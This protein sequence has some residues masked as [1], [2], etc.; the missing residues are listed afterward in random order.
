MPYA[1]QVGLFYPMAIKED[2]NTLLPQ[3]IN[4]QTFDNLTEKDLGLTSLT[5]LSSCLTESNSNIFPSQIHYTNL[6]NNYLYL[7]IDDQQHLQTQKIASNYIRRLLYGK[8]KVMDNIVYDTTSGCSIMFWMQNDFTNKDIKEV[9]II[10]DYNGTDNIPEQNGFYLGLDRIAFYQ[11]E[12]GS[13]PVTYIDTPFAT[14]FKNSSASNKWN[15]W[16]IQISRTAIQDQTANLKFTIKYIPRGESLISLLNN[17]EINYSIDNININSDKTIKLFGY[18]NFLTGENI[19]FDHNIRNL[20]FFNNALTDEEILQIYSNGSI[21]EYYNW[22]DQII[23]QSMIEN[24]AIF[25]SVYV[26]NTD[27]LNIIN[28]YLVED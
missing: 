14:Q 12:S 16:Y 27:M 1:N 18:K 11:K 2:T 22:E 21:N 4:N 13:I 24:S 9:P 19:T 25:G 5:T 20:M 26:Y 6:N 23:D 3:L 15:L 10:Y 8:Y 17:R 28:C 7:D